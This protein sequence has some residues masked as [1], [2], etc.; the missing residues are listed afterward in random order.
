MDGTA[1]RRRAT[2]RSILRG[3][4]APCAW[5]CR[6]IG[7]LASNERA[8]LAVD[9][10]TFAHRD[11]P[12]RDDRSRAAIDA[13]RPLER[14]VS[15]TRVGAESDERGDARAARMCGGCAAVRRHRRVGRSL[16]GIDEGSRQAASARENE[17]VVTVRNTPRTDGGS[18]STPLLPA[19]GARLTLMRCKRD[20]VNL[21]GPTLLRCPRARVGCGGAAPVQGLG[22]RKPPRHLTAVVEPTSMSTI[23]F[24]VAV[25]R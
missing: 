2:N 16:T 14:T 10:I 9:S 8:E 1:R 7:S 6:A 19:R 5:L 21:N 23:R 13:S 11:S 17:H 20:A 3:R 24:G 18:S 15:C 22:N 25:K 12:S 4:L